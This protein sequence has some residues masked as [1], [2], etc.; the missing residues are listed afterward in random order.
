MTLNINVVGKIY[1][2]YFPR[3]GALTFGSLPF[4][5]NQ[6]GLF[7]TFIICPKI[8]DFL[9]WG[10]VVGGGVYGGKMDFCWLYGPEIPDRMDIWVKKRKNR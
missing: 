5:P 10:G 6:N 8:G 1:D 2:V 7:L 4:V 3:T 9:W